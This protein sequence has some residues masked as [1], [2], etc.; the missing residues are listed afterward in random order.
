MKFQLV[1]R[2]QNYYY[3]EI[4]HKGIEIIPVANC[5]VVKID[6][7]TFVLPYGM[8]DYQDLL[9]VEKNTDINQLKTMLTETISGV[10]CSIY[11][12]DVQQVTNT[13]TSKTDNDPTHEVLSQT[14][15][16]LLEDKDSQV[17]LFSEYQDLIENIIE[18]GDLDV[19][20]DFEGWLLS[21]GKVTS[22]LITDYL[23]PALIDLIHQLD[24]SGILNDLQDPVQMMKNYREGKGEN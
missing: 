13:L 22:P 12:V 7:S 1:H 24:K 18:T 19:D 11:G 9:N 20:N 17:I 14:L 2:S 6:K 8:V 4:K 10:G 23:I 3:T 15:L 16:E 21:L 5:T